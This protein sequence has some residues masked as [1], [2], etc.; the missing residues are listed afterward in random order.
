LFGKKYIT[1]L[2]SYPLSTKF[3]EV[4]L[5]FEYLYVVLEKPEAK[6]NKPEIL[7]YST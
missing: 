7:I 5:L 6:F 1:I 4:K 3:N 2:L